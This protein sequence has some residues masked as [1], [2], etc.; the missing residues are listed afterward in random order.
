MLFV[1]G[2]S[3]AL[4][5]SALLLIK[6]KKSKSDYFLLLW[7]LVNALHIFLFYLH[8]TEEIYNY[9]YLLGIQFPIPLL[10]GVL[11]YFYVSSV[12]DQ[13]PQKRRIV[14]LHFVPTIT[15]YIYLIS[16]MQLP[17]AEKIRIFKS[18][19]EG[20]EI[21]QIVLL[22]TIFLSGIVYV[23]WS[24]ILLKRHKTNI[25][26]RFSDLENINLR[27]LRFLTYGLGIIW[28]L[29]IFI[30]TEAIIFSAV[31]VFVILIGF[32]GVY[33]KDIFTSRQIKEKIIH[34]EPNATEPVPK[35]KKYNKSGLSEESAVDYYQRLNK[36]MT[37][38]HLY[39]KSE[40]SL[41][42][43]ASILSIPSPYLSQII[44]E[45]EGKNFHDFING[46][47]VEAFKQMI[48]IPENRQFTLMALA[49]DCGFN[50]KSSFNRC[51]K[52]L[53]NQ[54]PSQYVNSITQ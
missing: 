52:K 29:V 21:F 3:I 15:L 2:I 31:S 39:K 25:R 10:H 54:T 48:S 5:I 8:Y 17:A 1:A 41:G 12:T 42:E 9:P 28:F 51:F 6:K 18:G 36:L 33:Q 26:N 43:L 11:L 23:I 13:F 44:N 37:E 16:F 19:G 50:S 46:Y 22:S 7:T 14:L 38:E 27:W 35:R 20:Y 49:Y 47:R 53:T 32:F 40:L 30:Q 34:I 45:T 24:S 4:F